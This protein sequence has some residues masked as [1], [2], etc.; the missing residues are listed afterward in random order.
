MNQSRLLQ[1]TYCENGDVIHVFRMDGFEVFLLQPAND[2]QSNLINYGVLPL[3]F[4]DPKDYDSIALGDR[5]RLSNILEGVRG[6]GRFRLVNE[7]KGIEIPCHTDLND[8]EARMLLAGGML[9]EMREG[10]GNT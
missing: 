8:R 1:T 6:D 9:S 4:D 2:V 7:T 10:G 3:L 5:M